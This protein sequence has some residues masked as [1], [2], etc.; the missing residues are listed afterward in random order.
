MTVHRLGILLILALSASAWPAHSENTICLWDRYCGC[1]GYDAAAET[2]VQASARVE[3]VADLL[4][5]VMDPETRDRQSKTAQRRLS[6]E[7]ADDATREHLLCFLEVRGLLSREAA[8]EASKKL[9]ADPSHG[10]TYYWEPVGIARFSYPAS[11]MRPYKIQTGPLIQGRKFGVTKDPDGSG[12]RPWMSVAIETLEYTLHNG[13]DEVHKSNRWRYH[14]CG[15]DIRYPPLAIP[16]ANGKLII[17]RC[18]RA[19]QCEWKTPNPCQ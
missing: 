2:A 18:R 14:L 19:E 16:P 11:Q 1:P 3:A 7:F 8:L 10:R 13:D 17:H 5:G 4:K 6:R 15:D 12:S 9:A